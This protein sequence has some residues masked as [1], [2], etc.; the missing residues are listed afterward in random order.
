[1]PPQRCPGAAAAPCSLC[2]HYCPVRAMCGGAEATPGPSA[3][4]TK[5]LYGESSEQ[6]FDRYL[7][8][9]NCFLANG[10][11]AAAAALR[12]RWGGCPLAAHPPWGCSRPGSPRHRAATALQSPPLQINH[13]VM[14]MSVFYAV[15]R[16]TEY[17]REL[18]QCSCLTKMA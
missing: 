13:R 7:T 15:G 2:K 12:R 11:G 1:M 6:G 16:M 4:S 18:K 5:P 10:R 9:V 3:S 17:S 14:L 8:D